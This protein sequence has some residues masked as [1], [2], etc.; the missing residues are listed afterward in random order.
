MYG[1]PNYG[2][3]PGYGQ[4]PMYGGGQPNYG[5][6]APGVYGAQV[7]PVMGGQGDPLRAWFDSV[8]IDRSGRISA[9]ELQRALQSGGMQFSLE[10]TARMVRM[11]DQNNTGSIDFP[12]FQQLHQFIQS[13]TQGF[14]SRD[15][16]GSGTLAA[17]EVF[18][19]LTSSGYNVSP[20][21]FD[22]LMRRFDSKRR[23]CLGFDDYIDLSITVSTAR[24]TF[25]F[26]DRARTGQ[27]TFNFENF[28]IAAMSMR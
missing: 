28:L 24:N 9:A 8:D 12:E 6:G 3:A 15:R 13:M 11:Y 1:Q 20:Q 27:V 17:G 26:Y 18:A 4:Q 10:T 22:F 5:G 19:A 21:T 25:A 14:R 7:T 16:D 2:G 23:G